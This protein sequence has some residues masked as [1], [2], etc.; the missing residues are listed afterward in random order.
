MVNTYTQEVNPIKSDI[1]LSFAEQHTEG[2]VKATK[3]FGRYSLKKYVTKISAAQRKYIQLGD[4]TTA[5]TYPSMI[6]NKGFRF[7]G[8][9]YLDTSFTLGDAFSIGM[10]IRPRCINKYLCSFSNGG[11][12]IV[13]DAN[14]SGELTYYD[15]TTRISSGV[16]LD[17]DRFYFVVV[18]KDASNNV[19]FYID[20]DLEGTG[21]GT[22]TSFD[23]DYVG[24]DDSLGN[25][26]Y[27]EIRELFVFGSVLVGVQI[28]ELSDGLYRDIEN[29]DVYV[30]TVSDPLS[31]T[32]L[33]MWDGLVTWVD[34]LNVASLTFAAQP[35]IADSNM[36][37][38][39]TADWTSTANGLLSKESTTPHD[40]QYLRLAYTD[41]SSPRIY[42]ASSEVITG[43][44]YPSSAWLR[45]AGTTHSANFKVGNVSV[46]GSKSDSAW[47][48]MA[49]EVT[50]TGTPWYVADSS[51]AAGETT[52]VDDF[53]IVN[54]SLSAL[55]PRAGTVTTAFAQATATAQPWQDSTTGLVRFDGTADFLD[56]S[57]AASDFAFIT[58]EATVF[59]VVVPDS[60][61]GYHVIFGTGAS[62]TNGMVLLTK[63]TEVEAFFA[64]TTATWEVKG[65]SG[66]GLSV[67]DVSLIEYALTSA[68]VLTLDVDGSEV[69]SSSPSKLA[70]SASNPLHFGSD[71]AG[72]SDYIGTLGDFIA[73]SRQLT[74]GERTRLRNK[75]AAKHGITL[76]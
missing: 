53:S 4:G 32:E 67:G 31:D 39:G 11:G 12:I 20:G 57:G 17:N 49:G 14:S 44:R 10:L 38:A 24:C 2:G 56:Y 22:D 48:L 68:G 19:K 64:N 58:S 76:P 41:T 66:S 23:L 6:G 73:F 3:N 46:A 26:Y 42:P 37:T 7:K 1:W 55:T 29:Q 33:E 16:A 34:P 59:Q 50:T 35:T 74:A 61:T 72:S 30:P 60:V 63:D 40:G 54:I 21:V 25:F 45:V 62:S 52:D 47:E 9:E 5:S 65:G 18:T 15:G 69:L 28:G 27:G 70:A 36:S 13:A 43:N 8:F 75:L 51:N 71:V